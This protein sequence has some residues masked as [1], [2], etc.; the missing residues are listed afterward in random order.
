MLILQKFKMEQNE[1]RKRI[2]KKEMKEKIK[3]HKIFLKKKAF[4]NSIKIEKI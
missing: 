4:L 1:I 2:E 3:I